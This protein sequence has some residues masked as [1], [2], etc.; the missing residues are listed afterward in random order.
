MRVNGGM[1]QQLIDALF[2][3]FGEHMLELFGFIVHPVPGDIER[4]CQIG[5]DQAVV[6]DHFKG[7]SLASIG[8][9]DALVWLINHPLESS[10]FLEHAGDGR[11]RV[12]ETL[13]K[14]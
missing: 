2:Q 3:V 7:D 14:H 13:G 6:A 10:Q 1:P 11:R 8:Q 4:L 12:S 9:C 5:F